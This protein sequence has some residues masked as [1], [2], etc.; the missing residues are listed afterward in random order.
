MKG[1]GDGSR[2]TVAWVGVIAGS[3][4]VLFALISAVAVGAGTGAKIIKENGLSSF[5]LD[6]LVML[7][8]STCLCFAVLWCAACVLRERAG[9]GRKLQWTLLTELIYCGTVI[10]L[11][12]VLPSSGGLASALGV[13]NIALAPQVAILYPVWALLV[14]SLTT[15]RRKDERPHLNI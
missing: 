8:C 7:V 11:V 14:L 5:Y 9:Y 10:L 2:S 4:G 15:L 6:Y 1:N 13:A 3:A 12:R